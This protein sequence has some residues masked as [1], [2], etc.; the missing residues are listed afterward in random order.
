MSPLKQS[1]ASETLIPPRPSCSWGH[2]YITIQ[3]MRAGQAPDEGAGSS[4]SRGDTVTAR[5]GAGDTKPTGTSVC[6]H[7]ALINVVLSSP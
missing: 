7:P 2:M 5:D 4:D 6:H 1:Q 3:P